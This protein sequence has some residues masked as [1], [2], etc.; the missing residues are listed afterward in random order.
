MPKATSSALEFTVFTI[1]GGTTLIGV[2]SQPIR[3]HTFRLA[4]ALSAATGKDREYFKYDSRIIGVRMTVGDAP[5]STSAV[6]DL[7]K[8]GTT[9]YTTQANRPSVSAASNTN[10]SITLPDIV[11]IDANEYLTV[12][13][14]T[15]SSA[16]YLA[17]AVTCIEAA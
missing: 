14:D 16:G 3:T 7:N 15:A 11:T 6:C 4:G 1:D 5:S 8:G 17:L 9:M 10:S 13:V 12:D 2:H